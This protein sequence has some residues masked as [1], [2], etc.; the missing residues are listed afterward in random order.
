ME[1]NEVKLKVEDI[2]FLVLP[3]MLEKGKTLYQFV[4]EKKREKATGQGAAG[5][6]GAARKKPKS[7]KL[8]F[9]D[10]W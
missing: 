3:E 10:P 5:T 8:R 1:E 9:T 7:D 4:Q 2:K 6:W